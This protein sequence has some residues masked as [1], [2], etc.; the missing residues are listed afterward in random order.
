M[1]Y[2]L[3]ACNFRRGIRLHYMKKESIKSRT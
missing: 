2:G 3:K 1:G